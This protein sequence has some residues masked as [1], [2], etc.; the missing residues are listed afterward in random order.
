TGELPLDWRTAIVKPIFKK[1]DKFDPDNYR[2][3]S[4]TSIVVK[5]LETIIY[6]GILCFLTDR[7]IIPPQQHGFLPGKSTTTNLLCCLADWSREFDAGNPVDVAY[8]DFAKAF[9]RVPKRRLLHKL[10]HFGIRGDLL[11]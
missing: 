11:K 1:G 7:H 9:D 6:D 10:N 5:L 8:C 2:P 4:L 3:I